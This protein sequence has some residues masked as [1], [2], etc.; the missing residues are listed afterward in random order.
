[1][2]AFVNRLPVSKAL[3]LPLELA[4]GATLLAP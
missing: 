4:G 3:G 1:L 2:Y